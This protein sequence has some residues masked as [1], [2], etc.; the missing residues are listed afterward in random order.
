MNKEIL[1]AERIKIYAEFMVDFYKGIGQSVL[2]RRK[3]IKNANDRFIM[4]WARK[5]R[6][7]NAKCSMIASDDVVRGLIEY[8]KIGRDAMLSQ[9]MPAV[10]G[11]FAKIAMMMR[12][13]LNPETKV[14]AEEILRTIVVDLDKHPGLLQSLK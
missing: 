8:D 4:E 2:A 10:L 1:Q 5:I 9:D 6:E 7:F 13:D 11:Q 14:T 12:K 3:G